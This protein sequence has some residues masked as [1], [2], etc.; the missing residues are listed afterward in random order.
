[1]DYSSFHNG[2]AGSRLSGFGYLTA[3]PRIDHMDLSDWYQFR[4]SGQYSVRVKTSSIVR[5]K[6][7]EEGGGQERLALESNAVDFD[8]LP[9]DADWAAEEQAKLDEILRTEAADSQAWRDALRRLSKLNT[10]ASAGRLAEMY[11]AGADWRSVAQADSQL[12]ESLQ[13]DVVIPALMSGLLNPLLT[14]PGGIANLIADLQTRE[15][16][17]VMRSHSEDPARQKAELDER[18]KVWQQYFQQANDLLLSSVQ[19]RSGPQRAAAI[20]QAWYNAEGLKNTG[21]VSESTVAELRTRVLA[22][23]DELPPELQR[24]LAS[25]GWRVFPHEQLLP[26]VRT[27]AR[28]SLDQRTAVYDYVR[29]WCEAEPEPCNT[30]ILDAMRDSKAKPYKTAALLLTEA[31]GPE[32]D[33]SLRERLRDPEMVRGAPD[34]QTVAALILRAGSR[35]LLPEV[36]RFL[37]KLSPH[38]VISCEIKANLLGYMFRFS[39]KEAGR[40][41]SAELQ[42]GEAVGGSQLL[43]TL[44]YDRYSDDLI[45]PAVAALESQNPSSAQ[46]AALFLM[47]HGPANIEDALWERLETLRAPWQKRA[48]ELQDVGIGFADSPQRR[49]AMLEQALASALMGGKNWKLSSSKTERLRAG[50]LTDSC[51]SIAD[52]KMSLGL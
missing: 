35:S 44:H 16:L 5:V 1:M 28:E 6:S 8:I 20:Y 27:F 47:E 7:T 39:V 11:L 3:T 36:R 45:P 49:A 34:A 13:L 21:G 9:A 22:V 42:S 38:D 32:L 33:P 24:Q 41:L 37:D 12:H 15:K 18:S 2:I 51:R 30:A 10:P 43:R 31:E 46:T 29:L 50:C 26:L 48:S 14:P 40:R 52:G 4:K 19:N 17:G 23:R 25:A